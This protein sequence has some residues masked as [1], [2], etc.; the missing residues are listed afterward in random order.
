M[1]P[2]D[3]LLTLVIVVFLGVLVEM[4]TEFLKNF[5]IAG[6]SPKDYGFHI[7]LAL[8]LALASIF[9]VDLIAQF[10]ALQELIAAHPLPSS[11]EVVGVGLTL[12][13]AITAALFAKASNILHDKT[14]DKEPTPIA[15]LSKTK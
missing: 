8:S 1:T 13:Q 2:T 6:F 12:G 15:I 11:G 4:I 10:P 5:Q 9:K 3:F 7:A 14:R